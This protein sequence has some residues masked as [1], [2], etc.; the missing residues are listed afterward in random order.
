VR[1][2]REVPAAAAA[3]GRKLQDRFE[4]QAVRHIFE[5]QNNNNNNNNKKEDCYCCLFKV[6]PPSP[7]PPPVP[8]TT[9]T[10]S[11]LDYYQSQLVSSCIMI[12]VAR[13]L[14]APMYGMKMNLF[15]DVALRILR[16][17]GPYNYCLVPIFF[18]TPPP[19]HGSSALMEDI[20]QMM[21]HISIQ[22][23]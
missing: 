17:H 13:T 9:T 8:V 22:W 23:Q 1:D 19:P 5:G 7:S 14:Q 11:C 15:P 4:I 12:E 2:D 18:T 6:C 3:A 16:K 10:S 20:S 21:T